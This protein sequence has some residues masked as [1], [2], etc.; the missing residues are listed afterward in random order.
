MLLNT[1]LLAY[2]HERTERLLVSKL[3]HSDGSRAVGG[4]VSFYNV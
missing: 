1:D 4:L 2:L 3:Q